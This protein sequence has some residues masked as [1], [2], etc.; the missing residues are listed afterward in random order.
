MN[1]PINCYDYV[2][3]VSYSLSYLENWVM[4]LGVVPKQFVPPTTINDTKLCI[5]GLKT[6][7]NLA[8][9]HTLFSLLFIDPVS[10]YMYYLRH[11]HPH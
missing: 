7:G 6:F 1:L 3:I 5:V 11:I 4:N 8:T 10:W 2:F 9:L